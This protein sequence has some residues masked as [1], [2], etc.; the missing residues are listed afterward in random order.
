MFP[1]PFPRHFSRSIVALRGPKSKIKHSFA[2]KPEG[3]GD[4]PRYNADDGHYDNSAVGRDLSNKS[5]KSSGGGHGGKK[6]FNKAKLL[7]WIGL[8]VIAFVL[9]KLLSTQKS[10]DI[11]SIEYYKNNP[12][13]WKE[14]AENGGHDKPHPD[15]TGHF[16]PKL[17]R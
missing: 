6:G 1:L 7:N 15:E 14:R 9:L 13:Y 8:P 16:N 12:D 2:S 4:K 11:H 5:L 17:T 3:P 10:S